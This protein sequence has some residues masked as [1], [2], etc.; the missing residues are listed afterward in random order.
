ME[1]TRR[2]EVQRDVA[3][4]SLAAHVYQYKYG[5][6]PAN[7]EELKTELPRV[8]VDPWGDGKETVGYVLVKGGLPDG[9]DR[10]LVY[11]RL[12]MTD[13]LFYRVDEPEY[14]IYN[15]DGS[16]RSLKEQKHGGQFLDVTSWVGREGGRWADDAGI[17]VNSWD[18]LRR[19]ER[20]SQAMRLNRIKPD[21]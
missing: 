21:V 11:F 20:A 5:R 16:N 10:P 12:W 6:W 13:G 1:L 9:S 17:G 7:L 15:S 14:G 2:V 19:E 8:A 3:A 18:L 4:M